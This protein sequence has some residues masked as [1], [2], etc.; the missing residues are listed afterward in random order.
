MALGTKR[1]FCM[2]TGVFSERLELWEPPLL[3]LSWCKGEVFWARFVG[4]TRIANPV[5]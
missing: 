1:S 4:D 3:E 5:D 2:D